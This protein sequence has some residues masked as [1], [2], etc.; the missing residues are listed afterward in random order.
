MATTLGMLQTCLMASSTD[1]TWVAMKIATTTA[2]ALLPLRA[3]RLSQ[4]L[5]ERGV[6]AED[7]LPGT[8]WRVDDEVPRQQALRL[9]LRADLM[10]LATPPAV[11]LLRWMDRLPVTGRVPLRS[12][13]A[14]WLEANPAH[15]PMLGEGSHATVPVRPTTVT[16]ITPEGLRCQHKPAGGGGRQ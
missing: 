4:W 9:E 14:R 15:D 8:L 10:Q 12:A 6:R 3:Q 2:P 5:L 1:Q 16:V 7:Y 11:Q 13:D